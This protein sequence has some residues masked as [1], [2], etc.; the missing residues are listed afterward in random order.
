MMKMILAMANYKK[1][2]VLL[3][4]NSFFFLQEEGFLLE[5]EL[6]KWL[7]SL[8]KEKSSSMDKKTLVRSLNKLQCEGKCKLIKLSMPLATN[9]R[10]NRSTVV[11]FQPSADTS[12]AELLDRV[13]KKFRKFEVDSRRSGLA[14]MKQD[15][16]SVHNPVMPTRKLLARPREENVFILAMRANGFLIAKMIRAKLLHKFL[17]GYI[18][19]DPG[20]GGTSGSDVGSSCQ[21]FDRENAINEMPLELFLQVVGSAKKIDNMISKCRLGVKLSELPLKDY[22]CLMN[23]NATARLSRIIDILLRLKVLAIHNECISLFHLLSGRLT[24]TFVF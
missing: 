13:Q 21:M 12:S 4:S 23:Y 8:D 15:N 22:K 19:Q 11:I 3:V 14:K 2:N 5:V 16:I 17:W 24:S 20:H 9:C 6:H 10:R 18:I 7:Q 1:K